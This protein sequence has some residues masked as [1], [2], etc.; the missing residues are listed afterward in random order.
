VTTGWQ[1]VKT[2]ASTDDSGAQNCQAA[3]QETGGGI[4]TVTQL[5]V[6][7]PASSCFGW[8]VRRAQLRCE[9]WAYERD[10]DL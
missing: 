2:P 8:I 3:S 7:F 6:L 4:V 10:K 5:L 9:R 1:G